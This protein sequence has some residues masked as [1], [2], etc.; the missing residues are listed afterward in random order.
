MKILTQVNKALDAIS[1][2]VIAATTLFLI[3]Q[4]IRLI[5]NTIAI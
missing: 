1:L 4:I 3:A 2:I 5:I